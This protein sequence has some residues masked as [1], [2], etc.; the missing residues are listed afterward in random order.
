MEI[1]SLSDIGIK[2]KDNQDNF[3]SSILE[4]DDEYEVGVLCLCDGMGGLQNG[5]LASRLVIESVKEY[6]THTFDFDGIKDVLSDVNLKIYNMTAG[7]KKKLMGTTCTIVV[8][9]NGNYRICHIGDSRCYLLH[10]NSY[11]IL[12]TDHSAV[13]KYGINKHQ[14]PEIYEKYKNKLTKCIGVGPE[15]DPDF[16]SGVYNDGDVFFVCSDGCWHFIEDTEYN[17]EKILDMRSLFNSCMDEGETDNITAT[18][19]YV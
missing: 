12:T 1:K 18:A 2:R 7:D 9:Y 11:D 14:N 19:L 4:V 3:W 5:A 6:F 8:C 13:M 10:D 17:R 16:Y 15:I